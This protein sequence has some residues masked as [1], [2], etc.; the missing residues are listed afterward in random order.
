MS[1][2]SYSVYLLHCS[3]IMRGFSLPSMFYPAPSDITF[4]WKVTFFNLALVFTVATLL[5]AF[6]EKPITDYL[7]G[8]AQIKKAPAAAPAP[9]AAEAPAAAAATPKKDA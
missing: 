7:S 1:R 8:R 5:Y 9:A 3:F 4:L 2:I 6:I